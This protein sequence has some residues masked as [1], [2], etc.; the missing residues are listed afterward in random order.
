[1]L[2][3]SVPCF[4]LPSHYSHCG[5]LDSAFSPRLCTEVPTSPFRCFCPCIYSRPGLGAHRILIIPMLPK[6]ALS[7][8]FN[9]E[10]GF[11]GYVAF[12]G[13]EPVVF[14]NSPAPKQA[15]AWLFS[16][17]PLGSHMVL[18]W[19]HSLYISCL[20]LWLSSVW[21]SSP[22]FA[23]SSDPMR[24]PQYKLCSAH[25]STFKGLL[26]A[27]SSFSWFDFQGFSQSSIAFWRCCAWWTFIHCSEALFII[28]SAACQF[29]ALSLSP[30][31]S[32]LLFGLMT[33]LLPH[34][35]IPQMPF[36]A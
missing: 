26:S 3:L 35:S 14:L 8:V 6:P 23:S 18:L 9:V 24:S 2:S 17:C 32:R 31:L 10:T 16:L 15:P 12:L 4:W 36:K 30:A 19:T 34:S 33:S 20:A 28:A 13:R 27:V 21:L 29:G 25:T 7:L 5:A 11:F 1:M 22:W